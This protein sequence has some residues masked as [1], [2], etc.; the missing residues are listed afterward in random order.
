MVQTDEERKQRKN[1]Q[2]AKWQKSERGKKSHLQ[3]SEKYRKKNPEKCSR[4]SMSSHRKKPEYYKQY[5]DDWNKKNPDKIREKSLKYRLLHLDKVRE[6]NRIRQN[7]KRAEDPEA[8][9]KYM[10]HYR[11]I[12][13]EFIKSQKEKWN[14][15]NPTSS[16]SEMTKYRRDHEMCEWLYC[17][18]YDILQVHHILPTFEYPELIE[19]NYH[20]GLENN[21]ICYC[22]FHHYA[23]HFISGIKK[24][25][26]KHRSATS[27]L[28]WRVEKWA[29]KNKISLEDLEI[30]LTQMIR[31]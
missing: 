4:A 27:L 11:K 9:K 12:N 17:E 13:A 22:P 7:K 31:N 30:E 24:N 8:Y 16:N 14:K 23:Y 10:Q 15:K 28:W 18:E 26:Q 21:L 2:T 5:V 20:G 6:S 29:K 1:A 25:S 19:G 3:S